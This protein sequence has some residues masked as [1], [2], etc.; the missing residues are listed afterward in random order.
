MKSTDIAIAAAVILAAS[1]LTSCYDDSGLKERIENVEGRV[2]SIEERINAINTDIAS[3]RQLIA[4]LSGGAVITAVEETPDGYRLTL[5]NGR[6]INVNHGRDGK[7]G[8]D[9]KDAPIIGVGEENGVY[10]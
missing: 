9:G 3:L 4:S 5:S 7:D 6:V 10:Y 1:G 8:L 2:Q